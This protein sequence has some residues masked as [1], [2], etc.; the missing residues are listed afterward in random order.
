[1]AAS[2]RSRLLRRLAEQQ[3]ALALLLPVPQQQPAFIV[4]PSSDAAGA[5][6]NL[7]THTV[8]SATPLRKFQRKHE[9]FHTL[10]YDE[11][12]DA[13]RQAI[14][15]IIAPRRAGEATTDWWGRSGQ[16]VGGN[17]GLAEKAAD[18]YAT[19]A[20][21]RPARTVDGMRVTNNVQSYTRIRPRRLRRFRTFLDQWERDRAA[22]SAG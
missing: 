14:A 12:T 2:T 10:D 16:G 15:R 19:A 3:A 4:D 17:A 9:K 13:D 5:G 20:T 11:F 22:S 7:Q 21:A 18:Y 1:M 8:T 6:N